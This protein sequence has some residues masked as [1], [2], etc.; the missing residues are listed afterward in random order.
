MKET[1]TKFSP[2]HIW[3][4]E[5]FEQ[6]GKELDT[7]IAEFAHRVKHEAR[8]FAYIKEKYGTMRVDILSL[9]TGGLHPLVYGHRVFIGDSWL[10]KLLW[11]IDWCLIPIQKTDFGWYKVG[12]CSFWSWIGLTKKINDKRMKKLKQI[13]LEVAEKY[14]NVKPEI[15]DEFDIFDKKMDGN[16]V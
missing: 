1:D 4:D 8:I 3:G 6:Y 16:V 12:L 11:K 15:M 7:A 13:W 14:P 5:W 2:S 10:A 9:W